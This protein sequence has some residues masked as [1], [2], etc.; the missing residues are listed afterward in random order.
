MFKNAI[1]REP[2]ENRALDLILAD[3][4]SGVWRPDVERLRQMQG[5][6]Y[7]VA[8]KRLPAFTPSGVFARRSKIAL[9]AHS[10]ILV[11]DLD[12]LD[13]ALVT[14]REMLRADTY[15][16]FVF[17]SPGGNGLKV[18]FHVDGNYHAESYSA[19]EDYLKAKGITIDPSCKDVSRLCFVSHDPDLWINPNVHILPHNTLCQSE[20]LNREKEWSLSPALGVSGSPAL[21][22]SVS[23]SLCSQYTVDKVLLLALPDM[24]HANHPSLFLL[25]RGIKRLEQQEGREWTWQERLAVFAQWYEN[26]SA[27]GILRPDQSKDTYKLEFMAAYNSAT[28]PL[29]ADELVTQAWTKANNDPPPQEAA[30]FDDPLIKK[31]IALCYA[32]DFLTGDNWYLPIRKVGDLFGKP[33]ST[34]SIWFRGLVATGILNIVEK[35]SPNRSTRYRYC[36]ATKKT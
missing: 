4:K 33:R 12:H 3:I 5:K 16:A 25:A 15:V 32:M 26:A 20:S 11:A 34:V 28:T 8:K 27:K 19:V 35:H 29:G 7:A 18:G 23:L 6:A 9:Q 24:P 31:F 36:V 30:M 10:G 2:I 22:L 1:A 13:G 14:T 21:P 17:V